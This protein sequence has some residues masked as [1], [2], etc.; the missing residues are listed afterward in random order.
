MSPFSLK[1]AMKIAGIPEEAFGC[2]HF[3]ARRV[4]AAK[5]KRESLMQ[6]WKPQT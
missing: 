6:Q 4:H 3:K 5:A 2:G 1:L